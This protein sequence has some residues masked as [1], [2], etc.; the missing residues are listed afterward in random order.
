MMSEE[1]QKLALFQGKATST[2][3]SQ[4]VHSNNPTLLSLDLNYD[5]RHWETGKRAKQGKQGWLPGFEASPVSYP[6]GEGSL[7]FSK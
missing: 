5:S 1:D 7:M 2:L 3:H 6:P 4:T